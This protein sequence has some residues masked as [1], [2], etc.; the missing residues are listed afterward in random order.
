MPRSWDE[1]FEGERLVGAPSPWTAINYD[2][3]LA[4]LN[5]RDGTNVDNMT[6][7]RIR[8]TT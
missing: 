8:L 6:P 1:N 7:E 5:F 2:G 3:H 4:Q